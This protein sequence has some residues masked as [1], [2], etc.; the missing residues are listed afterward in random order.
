MGNDKR[1]L[2][3]I[4]IYPTDTVWG[5][6]ASVFDKIAQESIAKIKK[7]EISKPNSV[8]FYNSAHLL[9]Y[10]S[11][12]PSI[13][14]EIINK[15]QFELG[16]SV[17]IKKDNFKS[18]HKYIP[19]TTDF[20]SIRIL[21]YAPIRNLINDYFCGHPIT[22][23]SLNFHGEN[24]IIQ[25]AQAIEFQKKFQEETFL[26]P[27]PKLIP[28]GL[29]STIIKIDDNESIQVIREGQN[30]KKILREYGL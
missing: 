27:I 2:N 25:E 1:N 7:T 11:H 16:L 10:L 13:L 23:T 15:K 28:Y 12:V 26:F 8:L 5:I 30:F 3:K 20:V 29:P 22:T 9:C 19:E 14:T 24:P 18:I 6:G 4:V 21:E 17:L